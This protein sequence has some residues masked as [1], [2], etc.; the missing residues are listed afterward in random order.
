MP[1]PLRIHSDSCDSLWVHVLGALEAKAIIREEVMAAAGLSRRTLERRLARARGIADEAG[2]GGGP[3]DLDDGVLLHLTHDPEPL[4]RPGP[5]WHDL[6]SDRTS[7]DATG[8]V[9]LV[10]PRAIMADLDAAGLLTN[11]A[12]LACIAV[13]RAGE[14]ELAFEPSHPYSCPIVEIGADGVLRSPARAP[15]GRAAY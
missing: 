3:P 6:A 12:L 4:R 8:P 13:Q 14:E 2:D 11:G 10:A 5:D 9:R 1:R 7:L 15:I